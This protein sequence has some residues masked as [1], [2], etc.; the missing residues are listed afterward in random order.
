MLT[1]A[2]DSL[3]PNSFNT[4]H[5]SPENESKLINSIERFGLYKPVICREVNGQLEII[6]GEHR[7]RAAK[8]IGLTEV[9]IVNLG[10]VSEEKARHLMLVDNG[11]Y[12]EDDTLALSE[13]LKELGTPDD[14]LSF[15]PYSNDELDSIFNSSSIELDDLD[16]SAED[17]DLDSLPSKTAQVSQLMRFK[18]PIEDSEFVQR[19][20]DAAMKSQG[21]TGEDSLSNAGHAL[22]YLLK[23]K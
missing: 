21:F 5:V 20:V 14:I 4:N 12:G 9:P 6:G 3:R 22:V 17:I 16:S 7:W 2:I 8:H 18:V 23:K 11:R 13:L 1:V 15:L 19:L 10:S